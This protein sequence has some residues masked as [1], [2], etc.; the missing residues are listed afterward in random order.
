[1]LL[2]S[3]AAL[4]PAALA[5]HTSAHF[6]CLQEEREERE[7]EY[8]D[9]RKEQKERAWQQRQAELETYQR[10]QAGAASAVAEEQRRRPEAARQDLM[11]SEHAAMQLSG[12]ALQLMK[13]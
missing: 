6:A 4:A 10:Q 8:L 12:D 13:R 1:M 9:K 3:P 5:G 2:P 11:A 7:A